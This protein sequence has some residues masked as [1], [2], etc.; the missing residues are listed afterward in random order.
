MFKLLLSV[1]LSFL[2]NPLDSYLHAPTM[3]TEFITMTIQT[4]WEHT[5]EHNCGRHAGCHV[6]YIY[7]MTL[8][9]SPSNPPPL[10]FM[11]SWNLQFAWRNSTPLR[12]MILARR[13]MGDPGQ[14]ERARSANGEH[15]LHFLVFPLTEQNHSSD[16]FGAEDR[17][18][19]IGQIPKA[20]YLTIILVWVH[21]SCEAW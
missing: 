5:Q 2:K 13:V 15:F 16:P 11:Q 3:I 8:F 19:F 7:S 1:S 14:S 20:D 10:Y 6:T 4:A 17:A 12:S 18:W 9:A 21:S